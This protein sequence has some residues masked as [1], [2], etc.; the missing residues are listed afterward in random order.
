MK[1]WNTHN[2]FGRV[3]FF[4]KILSLKVHFD[5]RAKDLR[6][7]WYL[8]CR[9][10]IQFRSDVCDKKEKHLFYRIT[11]IQTSRK[12]F[13][14]LCV[15]NVRAKWR[16]KTKQFK[17]HENNH[18]FD[19]S[20]ITCI[21]PTTLKAFFG[22]GAA[23]SRAVLLFRLGLYVHAIIFMNKSESVR[24]NVCLCVRL[25]TCDKWNTVS[26]DFTKLFQ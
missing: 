2:F 4:S 3:F 16:W 13:Q 11:A 6:I 7:C 19:C 23:V 1:C 5:T 21:V 17:Q 24:V 22:A 26:T 12:K 20:L 9:T 14:T 10:R 15:L 8:K 18:G 25:H